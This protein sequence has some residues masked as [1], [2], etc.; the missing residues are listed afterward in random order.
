MSGEEE[1]RLG[2]RLGDEV[3][4]VD[5][6]DFDEPD[7]AGRTSDV[8]QVRAELTA[9]AE[10]TAFP[11]DVPKRPGYR[12]FFATD[13]AEETIVSL[14]TKAT[15]KI[16]GGPKQVNRAIFSAL[17]LAEL[18]VRMERQGEAVELDGKPLT[19]KSR[20]FLDLY[21]AKSTATAIRKFF[22]KDGHLIVAA[23][24]VLEAAG[25]GDADLDPDDEPPADPS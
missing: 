1:R 4:D 3:P 7:V 8:D 22:R 10:E 9:E 15:K 17:I 23:D 2:A 24:K 20:S 19:F 14:R 6:D 11:V 13:I 25:W 18:F 16:E 21:E 12:V 5:D